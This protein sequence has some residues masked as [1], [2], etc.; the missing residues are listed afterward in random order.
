MVV[1]V[2]YLVVLVI[3]FPLWL[4]SLLISETGTWL[5]LAGGIFWL[6]RQLAR[7]LSYPGCFATVTRDIEKDY[8]RRL[9]QKL[10]A[11][12][13]ALWAWGQDLRSP[14]SGGGGVA[15][16]MDMGGQRVVNING[17][18]VILDQGL[19]A[20][21]GGRRTPMVRAA[22]LRGALPQARGAR[23]A[24]GRP[25]ARRLRGATAGGRRRR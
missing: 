9:V 22:P 15:G 8:S 13:Q 23:G 2:V 21:R 1:A 14:D 7:Y 6:G 3:W 5:A 19:A 20:S 18:P 4:L 25:R 24:R 12:A 17:Q 16:M 11:T 10:D